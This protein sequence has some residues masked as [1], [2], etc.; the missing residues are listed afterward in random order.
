MKKAPYWFPGLSAESMEALG[1]KMTLDGEE[2]M[3]CR[4]KEDCVINDM[5][6]LAS[7]LYPFNITGDDE[8]QVV[9]M[10]GMIIQGIFYMREESFNKYF[11]KTEA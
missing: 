1:E 5:L 11:Q 7:D 3:V 4:P 6:F 8:I 9:G 10:T 2:Y